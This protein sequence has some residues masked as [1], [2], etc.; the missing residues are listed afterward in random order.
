MHQSNSSCFTARGLIKNNDALAVFTYLVSIRLLTTPKS[1]S[2][3]ISE[4]SY[5]YLILQA[6]FAPQASHSDNIFTSTK[7][8]LRVLKLPQM[9][10]L[11]SI[12]HIIC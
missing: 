10:A 5:G 3:L 9:T 8:Y 11:I 1:Y 12:H 2:G 7:H 4:E 6:I